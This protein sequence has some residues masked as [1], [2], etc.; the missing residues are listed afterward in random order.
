MLGVVF[1]SF[2]PLAVTCFYMLFILYYFIIVL[3]CFGQK[4][5]WSTACIGRE[6]RVLTLLSSTCTN[7]NVLKF[8]PIT[9]GHTHHSRPTA[10]VLFKLRVYVTFERQ[11]YWTIKTCMRVSKQVWQNRLPCL[12]LCK[13]LSVL[14]SMACDCEVLCASA[15]RTWCISMTTHLLCLPG[16]D[17]DYIRKMIVW[18]IFFIVCSIMKF[19]Y[20]LQSTLNFNLSKIPIYHRLGLLS[21]PF[22]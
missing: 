17:M 1:R 16:N 13:M 22:L 14:L 12:L 11:Y 21:A 2:H 18:K 7:A 15:L 6:N 3:K 10:A 4:V 5:W 8:E 9:I 19:N 20:E